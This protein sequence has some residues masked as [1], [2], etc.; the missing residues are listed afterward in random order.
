MFE[1]CTDPSTLDTFRWFQLL[2]D[3]PA[4]ISLFYQVPS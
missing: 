4:R 3:Q 2:P 1:F